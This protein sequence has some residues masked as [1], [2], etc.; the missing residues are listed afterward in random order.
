[1][2]DGK[3]VV[4]LAAL[5]IDGTFAGCPFCRGTRV[6]MHFADHL[7]RVVCLIRNCEAQGPRAYEEQ[8]ALDGWNAGRPTIEPVVL[9][10]V[11]PRREDALR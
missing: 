10:G 1:V 3:A 6:R 5:V 4:T 7:F 2:E 8:D 9:V 11:N